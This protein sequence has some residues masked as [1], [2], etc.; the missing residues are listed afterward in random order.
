MG[1]LRATNIEPQSG[2]NLTLGASGD[3]VTISG[4][5]WFEEGDIIKYDSFDIVFE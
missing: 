4:Q 3:T 2:T 1:K 5:A